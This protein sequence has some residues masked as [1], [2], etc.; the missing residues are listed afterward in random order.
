MVSCV[1]GLLCTPALEL[2]TSGEEP[3]SYIGELHDNSGVYQRQTS[4][5]GVA[6]GQ[7]NTG[8]LSLLALGTS[9]THA[10]C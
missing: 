7:N 2:P 9:N 5:L 6:M 3:A 8:K 1:Q 10:F 4:T